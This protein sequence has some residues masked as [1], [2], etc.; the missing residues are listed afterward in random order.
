MTTRG[1]ILVCTAVV[2]W[3]MLT[4]SNAA[5]VILN[6]QLIFL[7]IAHG[8]FIVFVVLALEGLGVK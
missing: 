5:G 8:S 7:S 3:I 1:K 2:I 4:I 6:I